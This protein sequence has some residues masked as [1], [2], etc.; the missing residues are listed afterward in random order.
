[1]PAYLTGRKRLSEPRPDY[2]VF[3][4]ES[5]AVDYAGGAGELW[6]SVPGAVTWLES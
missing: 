6:A 5:E 3:G 1:V 4:E 2:T